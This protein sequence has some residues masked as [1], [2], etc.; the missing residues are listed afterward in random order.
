MAT[1]AMNLVAPKGAAKLELSVRAAP[2]GCDH[3]RKDWTWGVDI[4]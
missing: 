4:C 2:R 1:M 3:V